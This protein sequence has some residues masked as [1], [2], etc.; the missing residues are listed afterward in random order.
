MPPDTISG[1]V[2]PLVFGPPAEPVRLAPD[3]RPQLFRGL[4]AAH[5]EHVG[6]VG[7]NVQREFK[8]HR[9]GGEVR[10]GNVL[11]EHVRIDESFA[12]QL[13]RFAP[14]E[15]LPVLRHVLVRQPERGDVI[16]AGRGRQQ[17]GA[18]SVQGE[19]EPA[20]KP[21][22]LHIQP[23]RRLRARDIPVTIGH[24]E[25]V[26]VFDHSVIHGV[27]SR[28]LSFLSETFRICRTKKGINDPL[29]CECFL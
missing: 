13:H 7:V 14:Q 25:Q 3:D 6:E 24:Q 16:F 23:V 1:T 22:V 11:I 19:L 10:Q 29:C 9:L 12:D 18:A 26:V 8:R 28:F 27:L 2:R 5:E 21:R 20:Q 4:E 15:Q 17:H